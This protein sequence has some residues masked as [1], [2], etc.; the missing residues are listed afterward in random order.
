MLSGLFIRGPVILELMPRIRS[1]ILDLDG[2]L[3]RANQPIGNLP[4]I[5]RRMAE[6]ELKVIL[7]TNNATL[8]PEQYVQKFARYGVAID[9]SQVLNS[10]MAVSYLLKQRFPQ[11]GTVFSIGEEGLWAVLAESGFQQSEN[12]V[13]AVV[14]S[15]DRQINFQKLTRA[16]LLVRA[17]VPF[18]ATNSD[19]TYPTPD[20]LIPG[21][22]AL[23]AALVAATDVEP[24]LGGKPSP[25]MMAMAMERTGTPPD[26]TLAVGDRLETDI[27]GG[28]IAGCRTAL[29]LSGV[30]TLAD[31][32]SAPAQPTLIAA[33]LS[34]LIGLV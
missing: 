12:N 19:R 1:L 34:A 11:G 5:F 15:M 7:A 4:A 22:G 28:A 20:G 26:Q 9:P 21:A 29:V 32:K 18:Y 3:W 6:L 24:I 17:G 14:A 16:T 25:T 31:L 27:L 23:L 10:A 13:L 8:S 33:D 2:V 30:S